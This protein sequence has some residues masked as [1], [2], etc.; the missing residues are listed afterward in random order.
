[1]AAASKELLAREIPGLSLGLSLQQVLKVRAMLKRY[2]EGDREGLKVFHESLGKDSSALYFFDGET[3]GIGRLRRV[4]IASN[5]K[6]AEA[7]VARV[8]QRET[9]LG[10]PTGVWDC[11]PA[12]GQIPSRRYSY[13]RGPASAMEVYV[14][15]REQTA[16][17]YYVGST[18]DQRASLA[19]AGC[20]PTPPERAARFPVAVP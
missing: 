20:T 1:L 3:G 15:V 9:Q 13:K 12:P 2:A 14:L 6:N 17:T 10:P 16:I 8:Q 5:V 7:V 18:S 4:Q 11:P 19:Q